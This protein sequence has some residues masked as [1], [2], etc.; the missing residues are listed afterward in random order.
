MAFM[1]ARVPET[2]P[3]MGMPERLQKRGVKHLVL[4]HLLCYRLNDVNPPYCPK[5]TC[6]GHTQLCVGG[7][8]GC[9]GV[10]VVSGLT[11]MGCKERTAHAE[12]GKEGPMEKSAGGQ[13]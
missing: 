2:L 12:A 8:L 13:Q 3:E 11:V 4:S 1:G 6:A 7:A 5:A 10:W 9:A